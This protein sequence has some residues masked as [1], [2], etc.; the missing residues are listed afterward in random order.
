M[1]KPSDVVAY[2]VSG[3]G[4]FRVLPGLRRK[5]EKPSHNTRQPLLHGGFRSGAAEI[6]DVGSD[7]GRV[8]MLEAVDPA[9]VA[10]AKKS[11]TAQPHVPG[12]LGF[13]MFAGKTR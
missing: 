1:L 5:R 4:T 6:F 7:D 13:R 12:G 9:R 11:S 10:P 3:A 2:S 8:D